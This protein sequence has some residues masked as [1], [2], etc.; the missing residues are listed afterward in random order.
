MELS[1]ISD[2]FE[3]FDAWFA[4]ARESEPNDPDAMALATVAADGT[5]SVRMVLMKGVDRRGFAFYTNLESRKGRELAADVRAALCFHW[6]SQRRQIRVEGSVSPVSAEDA[7]RYFASRA[8]I[9]RLGAWASF[10]SRPLDRRETL[11]ARVA[12]FDAK[13][14]G[15]TVPRPP[16]WSG[17]RLAPKRFEFWEDRQF[18]LH[19]RIEYVPDGE[20]WA[21]R[22]LYP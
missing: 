18:R 17:F 20:G 12:E 3:L 21:G 7:D 8:R 11:E 19:D 4:T 15:E 2:P 13:Y 6:K 16:H 1:E 14:P 22:R 9:S 10:Q 5:P